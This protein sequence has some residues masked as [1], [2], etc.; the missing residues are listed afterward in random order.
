MDSYT[1]AELLAKEPIAEKNK[2]IVSND[3][4][5]VMDIL[6]KYFKKLDFRLSRV[7]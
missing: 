6:E 5:A 1:T 7:K 3:A 4:Y 2:I